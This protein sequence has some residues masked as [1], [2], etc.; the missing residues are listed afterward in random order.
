MRSF[1]QLL[2]GIVSLRHHYIM[3]KTYEPLTHEKMTNDYL[4]KKVSDY[5][6]LVCGTYSVKLQKK[7]ISENA[8]N[9]DTFLLIDKKTN[10][11]LGIISVMY[12]GGNEL[13]YRIRRI[14][15]FVYNVKIDE[16]YQG[17]G[18]VS[19]MLQ[20]LGQYLLGKGI[21]DVYLAVSTDNNNAIK[22]YSK[23]GFTIVDEKWFIRFLKHNYPYYSL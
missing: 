19:I 17:K 12:N 6:S 18:Y 3:K 20:Y 9:C 16:S 5:S 21:K 23:N 8:G 4:L 15:A 14:D 2:R 11:T 1:V 22:A 10:A 13:E 7:I